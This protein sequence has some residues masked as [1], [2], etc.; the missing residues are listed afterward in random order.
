MPMHSLLG[1]WTP[2]QIAMLEKGVLLAEHRLHEAEVFTDAGLIR[3][4]D[5]H[6]SHALTVSTMGEEN[7]HFQWRDGD[8]NGVPSDV[9]IDLVKKGRLWLNLRN[10]LEY[11]LELRELIVGVYDELESLCPGFKAIQRSGNLLISSPGCLVHY[12][13][14]VPVNMLWHLRGQKRVWV[15]PS[16]D[17]RFAP[18][19][20]VELVCNSEQPEDIPYDPS[21]DQYALVFD[22]EPGQLLTWPQ[23]TPH[24]VQNISGLNVSLSTEHYN[25][26]AKL[27]LNVHLANQFFRRSFG[28][29]PT[30]TEIHGLPAHL[31]QASIRAVRAYRKLAGI[32]PAKKNT[33]PKTFVVN[34]AA[35]LGFSLLNS[36]EPAKG[37]GS[38]RE[39]M[40]VS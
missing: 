25:P 35:P 36:Q 33:Y 6:P 38:R 19:E 23:M 16:F 30:S 21:F 32:Q 40:L 5:Q 22:V 39:P 3:L 12:H 29:N 28:W 7:E 27:R 31:K 37:S 14:D 18:R 34:P 17:E 4:L 13:L 10:V 26:T 2:G 20:I 24:R 1:N 8:R 15:Y 9:L 11:S